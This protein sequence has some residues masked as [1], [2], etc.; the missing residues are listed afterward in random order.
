METAN[1]LEV[2]SPC[3]TQEH[4]DSTDTLIKQWLFRFAVNFEKDVAPIL[5]L[6]QETFSGIDAK[7][8]ESLFKR[9]FTTCKFFPKVADI[10]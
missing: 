2:I 7:T 4:S 3:E 10:L 1:Q 5:P 8:L 9:A 6:W